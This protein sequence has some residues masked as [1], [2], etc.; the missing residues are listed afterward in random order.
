MKKRREQ[1]LR[2][3]NITLHPLSKTRIKIST[4]PPSFE[5]YLIK[6]M[7]DPNKTQ[8]IFTNTS[9]P[10]L[11]FGP[12]TTRSSHRCLRAMVAW[13]IGPSVTRIYLAPPR[14]PTSLGGELSG[15]DILCVSGMVICL[16]IWA[17]IT[18]IGAVQ[19][20]WRPIVLDSRGLGWILGL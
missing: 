5:K 17:F 7:Q 15:P 18:N 13:L 6:A 20:L 11:P 1:H 8:T 16:G 3:G 9:S 2:V 10:T 12:A 14:P 4:L 19:Y